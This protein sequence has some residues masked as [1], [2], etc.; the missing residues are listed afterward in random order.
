VFVYVT[1]QWPSYKGEISTGHGTTNVS[2]QA[3][4][5]D[6]IITSPSAD[7]LANLGPTALRKLKLSS[8]GKSIDKSR[9]VEHKVSQLQK[10]ARVAER[11]SWDRCWHFNLYPRSRG[12]LKIKNQ[13]PKYQITHPS[14]TIAETGDVTLKL[15]YNVQPWVGLLTWN[16]DRDIGLWR[17]M[18]GGISSVVRL[19]AIKKKEGEAKKAAS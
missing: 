12:I 18:K 15:H 14:G 5:W 7:H 6:S 9:S 8:G 1:A 2:N 16:Q 10:E 11:L 17:K 13:K 3:V 19:P 4:I